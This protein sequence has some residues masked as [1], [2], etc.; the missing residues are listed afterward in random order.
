[1]RKVLERQDKERESNSLR[2]RQ[3]KVN[4]GCKEDCGSEEINI[5]RT[6]LESVLIKYNFNIKSIKKVLKTTSFESIEKNLNYL[7]GHAKDIG[8]YEHFEFL[9]ITFNNVLEEENYKNAPEEYIS[10]LKNYWKVLKN[11]NKLPGYSLSDK[12][13]IPFF[14]FK[15]SKNY[16]LLG[17]IIYEYSKYKDFSKNYLRDDVIRER[18]ELTKENNELIN[19]FD[20]FYMGYKNYV[21][22]PY[23]N[24][25]N[26]LI[27]GFIE[28]KNKEFGVFQDNI[29]NNKDYSDTKIKEDDKER[30]VVIF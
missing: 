6:D 27:E 4:K 5:K 18:D 28:A 25:K 3:L 13:T 20:K 14:L 2:D 16:K 23:Y 26:S 24:N 21:K 11:Q 7:Y 12:I 15:N 19:Q 17:E 8:T 9:N 10:L 30:V 29:R 22:Q 1:L